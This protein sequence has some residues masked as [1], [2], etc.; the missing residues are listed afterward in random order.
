[1]VKVGGKVEICPVGI[2]FMAIFHHAI[3]HPQKKQ[4]QEIFHFFFNININDS[5]RINTRLL[6]NPVCETV[7]KRELP[8][9]HTSS[10]VSRPNRAVAPPHPVV[11]S[12][13]V[14]GDICVFLKNEMFTEPT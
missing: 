3:Q 5:S 1:M 6:P 14:K 11:V 13:V 9:V 12:V 4:I 7:A 2:P 8:R 10:Q